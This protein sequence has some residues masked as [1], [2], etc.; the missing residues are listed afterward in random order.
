ML[1]GEAHALMMQGF[2]IAEENINTMVQL[3]DNGL[4]GYRWV[5]EGGQKKL[6]LDD[7]RV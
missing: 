1:Q 4:S 7:Q 3:A 6:Y 5:E 2:H